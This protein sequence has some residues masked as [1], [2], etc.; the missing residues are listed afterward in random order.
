M[1]V[2]VCLF[3]LNELMIGHRHARPQQYG[4]VTDNDVYSVNSVRFHKFGGFATVGDDGGINTWD[5]KNRT[6]LKQFGN[7]GR[8]NVSRLPLPV[9]DVDFT[10]G[11]GDIMVY[12]TSYTWAYG[13]MQYNKDAQRPRIYLHKV[14]RWEVDPDTPNPNQNKN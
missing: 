12:A 6:R 10:Y 8:G 11:N 14:E 3:V 2:C 7:D 4:N 1:C 5:E 13:A 9:V